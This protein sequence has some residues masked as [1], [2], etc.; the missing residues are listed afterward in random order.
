MSDNPRRRANARRLFAPEVIQ[1]SAMDC[2][3]ASLKCLVEGFGVSVSY[4]RLREACQT[5]VDGTSIDT[6]EEIAAELG[7]DAE[8]VMVPADHLF[9]DEACAL[10][11]IVVIRLPNGF[12]HFVVAW[13]HAGG[14]V[15]VMDPATGRRYMTEDA[16]LAQV[17]LHTMPV[18]AAAFLEWSTGDEFRGALLRQLS[19]LGCESAARPLLERASASSSYREIATLDAA[20]R[21]TA[22]LVRSGAIKRGS[23]AS[24][25]LQELYDQS[26]NGDAEAIP[27]GYFTARPAPPG[28]DGEE[29]VFLRGVPL[30][31]AKGMREGV[32]GARHEPRSAELRAALDEPPARPMQD[33]LKILR[34]DGALAPALLLF[35]LTSSA[36]GVALEAILLRSALSV[37]I[38]LGLF[39]QRLG[40]A[41]AMLLFVLTL[42]ALEIPTIIEARRIGRRIEA[43]LRLAFLAK[44]PRLHDRYLQSR[45]TSDMAERSHAIHAVRGLSDLTAQILAASLGIVSTTAGIVWLDPK[46]AIVALPAA[47]VCGLL[48]IAA[49][50]WIRERDMRARTHQGALSRFYLDALLGLV[51]VRTHGAERA[52]RREHES[53]LV[54]WARSA[55]DLLRAVVLSDTL[56]S[57][58]GFGLAALL[59]FRYIAGAGDPTGVLLLVYWALNLPRLGQELAAL[60]RQIPGQQN[61]T[62]RLLEPLGAL[63]ESKTDGPTEIPPSEGDG[64]AVDLEGVSVLAGGHTILA[65]ADLHIAPGAHVA[66][67]GASGAG[68]STLVGL[69]LGFHRPSA[70]RVLIN[71]AP[72]GAAMQAALRR[73]TAWVDPSVQLW[74]RSLLDN[75]RYGARDF[76]AASLSEVLDAADL[77]TVLERLPDGMSTTLGEGGALVS[78]GEGQRVRLG[79]ALSREAPGLV[80]L[81]EALRGLD[82]EKR[83][84]LLRRARAHWKSA[85]MIC[86]THDVGE[87]MAFDRVLVVDNGRIVEDGSPSDLAASEGSRYRAM[88]DAELRVREGLWS[89]PGWRRMRLDQGKLI[90][91][92]DAR[93]VPR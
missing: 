70:G 18:P 32:D 29:R 74:N 85:T 66:V 61:I 78:G 34:V 57:A 55:L 33:L 91:Q 10:P 2:G 88:L 24:R 46:S 21:T 30:V 28:E 75:L 35:T 43:R 12:T 62:L 93:E 79:R 47:A 15:Q 31:R 51:P 16:F 1:T 56:A 59:L 49:L 44:L 69:L 52:V 6:L 27:A 82:R 42:L 60:L 68:K 45:P 64:I 77:H 80:I 67:I 90:E 92:S 89:E 14:L 87:T 37:G 7:L 54:A 63:E 72:L 38:D 86:A 22:S 19:N 3:P 39:Q 25:A 4:G 84:S 73:R 50:P 23:E 41:A 71:G 58:V 9:L 11:A 5:D 13:N 26:I 53:L 48:P 83:R 17:F 76:G 36:I 65:D 40:A 20:T 8:Q 81:D